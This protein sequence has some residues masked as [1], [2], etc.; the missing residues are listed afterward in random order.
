MQSLVAAP[1]HDSNSKDLMNKFTETAK[2]GANLVAGLI[3][4]LAARLKP[5]EATTTSP[6]DLSPKDW[7]TH[8]FDGRDDDLIELAV[9]FLQRPPAEVV[10]E[11][12]ASFRRDQ[13]DFPST[14][15]RLVQIATVLRSLSNL[16]REYQGGLVAGLFRSQEELKAHILLADH[17][18]ALISICYQKHNLT[19]YTDY[20]GP[21]RIA[22][23]IFS[24]ID[25]MRQS[26]PSQDTS[27][28]GFVRF[29][30]ARDKLIK[31]SPGLLEFAIELV[32]SGYFV[33][34]FRAAVLKPM[35]RGVRNINVAIDQLG[36]IEELF[37]ICHD[38]FRDND[39]TGLE[40][41][42]DSAVRILTMNSGMKG[43]FSAGKDASWLRRV[44]GA[45]PA[46]VA[47]LRKYAEYQ[48]AFAPVDVEFCRGR[49]AAIAL[50]SKYFEPGFSIDDVTSG[51]TEN[52]MVGLR[53]SLEGASFGTNYRVNVCNYDS[54]YIKNR[55]IELLRGNALP[56]CGPF[57]EVYRTGAQMFSAHLLD[58][59]NASI[60]PENQLA[61]AP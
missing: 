3:S 20:R 28:D 26:D 57:E 53:A 18:R 31:S 11:V 54:D 29:I 46:V 12:L 41:S 47:E 59:V 49:N 45:I 42:V 6:V 7:S 38:F 36:E 32:T 60:Y 33:H 16:I 51:L 43:I 52:E 4:F 48:A 58:Q 56:P 5:A 25:R 10:S 40:S 44:S 14:I 1:D 55:T 23:E 21:A 35:Y 17:S 27:H 30:V 13:D 19:Q 50:A 15:A 22:D 9:S 2:A 61:I 39:P 34:S 37:K 8:Q 24:A